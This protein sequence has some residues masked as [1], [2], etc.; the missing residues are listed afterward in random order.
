MMQHNTFIGMPFESTKHS[1]IKKVL[2]NAVGLV[3]M[4]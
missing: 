2:V 4:Q 3:V 1:K